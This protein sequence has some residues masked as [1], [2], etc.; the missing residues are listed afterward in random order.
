VEE[1]AALAEAGAVR[2]MVDVSDGLSSDLAHVLDASGAGAEVWADAVPVHPDAVAM[3][4]QD[5][6]SPLD[7]ALH[8]GEDFEL[9]FTLPVAQASRFA[10]EGLAGTRV[11]RI[12]TVVPGAGMVLLDGEGAQGTGRALR[13]GG[14]DHFRTM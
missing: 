14:F 3:S 8:D 4:R 1:A 12:G 10:R 5:G 7:H 9:C 2:A 11:T 6:R 13:R